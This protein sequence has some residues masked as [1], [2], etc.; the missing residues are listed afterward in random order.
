M[1]KTIVGHTK[2]PWVLTYSDAYYV[3]KALSLDGIAIVE[4]GYAPKQEQEANARLIAAA[5]ELLAAL[6]ALIGAEF[7][8][9]PTP[10]QMQSVKGTYWERY[11]N[12]IAKAEGK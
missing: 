5:P 2:G 6:K 8:G 4:T 11:M 12:L 10:E 9:K 3:S 7:G 1:N